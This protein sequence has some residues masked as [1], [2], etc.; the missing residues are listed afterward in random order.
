MG[1]K[2]KMREYKDLR[3]KLEQDLGKWFRNYFVIFFSFFGGFFLIAL[4]I[5]EAPLEVHR[6]LNF[7]ISIGAI[8]FVIIFG[9]LMLAV[10]IL[11]ILEEQSEEFNSSTKSSSHKHFLCTLWADGTIYLSERVSQRREKVVY[12]EYKGT[13]A[14]LCK[15]LPD[16]FN[17]ESTSPNIFTINRESLK[18]EI[19]HLEAEGP[20]KPSINFKKLIEKKEDK[21]V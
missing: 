7:L 4:A 3:E 16:I 15:I 2:F 21:H 19:P 14:D 17:E 1:V 8:T 18:S 5:T 11:M 9:E 10:F 12:K 20:D 13:V 6:F